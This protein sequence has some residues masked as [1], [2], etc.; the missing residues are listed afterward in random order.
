MT[1]VNRF[2]LKLTRLPVL[3]LIHHWTMISN[4]ACFRTLSASLASLLKRR[5]RSWSG[6]T[7][8][9]RTGC[10]HGSPWSRRM[11]FAAKLSKS[12]RLSRRRLNWRTMVDL[13]G[14]IPCRST[15]HLRA[16]KMHRT[17]LVWRR[18]R[19]SWL[20]RNTKLYIGSRRGTT[21]YWLL[22]VIQKLRR[23][24]APRISRKI[25]TKRT[26]KKSKRKRRKSK[27]KRRNFVRRRRPRRRKTKLTYAMKAYLRNQWLRATRQLRQ[28]KPLTFVYSSS[29][30]SRSSLRWETQWGS[31][32]ALCMRLRSMSSMC[33]GPKATF[34][35]QAS[36][37]VPTLIIST[38]PISKLI[39]RRK[40]NRQVSLSSTL[41]NNS[42]IKILA[43]KPFVKV[44]T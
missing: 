24:Y 41:L 42:P 39:K 34:S 22:W 38:K 35:T 33:A 16:T 19:S 17:M 12:W 10:S 6:C 43:P 7:R 21:S 23:R 26:R 44:S 32:R 15:R 8:R 2:C 4:G 25:R 1:N 11:G 9:R 40:A 18:P 5:N 29:Q 36:I 3:Q 31:L 13:N 37:P 28:L 27:R 14:F 20:S 30:R